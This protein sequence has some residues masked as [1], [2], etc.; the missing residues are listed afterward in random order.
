MRAVDGVTLS[1]RRGRDAGD[2]GRVGVRE[3]HAGQ[4]DNEA[5]E[6]DQGEDTV[7]RAPTSAG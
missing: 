6:P 3:D 1:V 5:D 7:R 2:R 4:D